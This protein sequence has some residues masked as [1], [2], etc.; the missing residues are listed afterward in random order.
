M[1]SKEEEKDYRYFEEADLPPLRVSDWKERIDIPELPAARRERFR[2]EYGLGEEAAS[3]LTSTKQVADFYEHVASAFDPDLAATWVADN[4]LGELHYRD[5]AITDIEARLDEFTRL[6]ELV[7]EDEITSKNAE[8]V[9]LRS[10]LDKGDD[11]DTIV[12]REGLEK[13]GDDA[14]AKAVSAAIDE[15]PDAVGDYHDGQEDALN[16][17]VGQVMGATGGSADPGTVNQLLRKQLDK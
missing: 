16:F 14:V 7:D 4:L 17:L 15:N 2:E 1:R 3:K 13:T 5:M 8:E 10:M 11:P 12:E 6:I 9:V